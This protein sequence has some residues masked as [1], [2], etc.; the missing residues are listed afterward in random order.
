MK[1]Q[2]LF[3]SPDGDITLTTE[4]LARP[5][6][7]TP[8]ESHPFLTLG[9]YFGSIEAFLLKDTAKPLFFILKE[10]FNKQTDINKIQEILIRSEKHGALYH[11][12]S[13]EILV[14][15]QRLKLAVSTAVSER[16]KLW[17]AREYEILK[18]HANRRTSDCSFNNLMAG[19]MSWG[20]QVCT[21]LMHKY[22]CASMLGQA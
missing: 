9:D 3:S 1:I 19:H 12:A 4:D 2:Y 18:H 5:F 6:L 11:P 21:H 17:I 22:T 14:D 20:I 7:I 8:T 10:R 15:G 13:I 16:G